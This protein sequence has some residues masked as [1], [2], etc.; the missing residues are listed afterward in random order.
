M[1][2]SEN[3][4]GACA[5]NVSV[6]SLSAL[7]ASCGDARIRNVSECGCQGALVLS[8]RSRACMV[9][10][11]RTPA[12]VVMRPFPYALQ[13]GVCVR[14]GSTRTVNG[15]SAMCSYATLTDISYMPLIVTLYRASYRP[16]L[17]STM[18]PP[19]SIGKLEM[20]YSCKKRGC[21]PRNAIEN[22]S[23]PVTLLVPSGRT[24]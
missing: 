2:P 9:N 24:A 15:L 5:A 22:L 13:F 20:A 11:D 19:S 23:L 7:D 18:C 1:T 16:L 4:S 3:V 10:L 14:A 17:L 8:K 12:S 21:S 6:R